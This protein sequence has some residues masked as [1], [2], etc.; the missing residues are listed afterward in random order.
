[1]RRSP[2]KTGKTCGRPFI[3]PRKVTPTTTNKKYIDPKQRKIRDTE[4]SDVQVLTDSEVQNF[5][6]VAQTFE[7]NNDSEV[8]LI[9]ETQNE[10]NITARQDISP[11]RICVITQSDSTGSTPDIFRSPVRVTEEIVVREM[12]DIAVEEQIIRSSPTSTKYRGFTYTGV[13][14]VEE[15]E[16]QHK[17]SSDSEDGIPF[18]TLLRQEKGQNPSPLTFCLT[19]GYH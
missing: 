2:R 14:R 18:T 7:N 8:Q 5:W 16:E 13:M 15:T 9:T 10:R 4:D 19:K 6:I 3:A 1:M 12:V 17:D 11:E